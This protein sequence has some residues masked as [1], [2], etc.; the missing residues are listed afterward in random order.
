MNKVYIV[1]TVVDELIIAVFVC[2][3]AAAEYVNTLFNDGIDSEVEVTDSWN[4]VIELDRTNKE[5]I[6]GR[7]ND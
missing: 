4:R 3:Y 1:K 2:K 6:K 7:N 5:L